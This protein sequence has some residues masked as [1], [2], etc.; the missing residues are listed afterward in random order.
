MQG[1]RGRESQHEGGREPGS[2]H[3]CFMFLWITSRNYPRI[4]NRIYCS[5]RPPSAVG[6]ASD[7]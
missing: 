1:G 3:A 7:S 5:A 6:S 4:I 2:Q